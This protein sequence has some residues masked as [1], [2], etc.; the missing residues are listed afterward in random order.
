MIA[1]ALWLGRLSALRRT[2]N[3]SSSAV[4]LRNTKPIHHNAT[5]PTGL[6]QSM[7]VHQD[8]GCS[9]T[10]QPTMS[11]AMVSRIADRSIRQEKLPISWCAGSRGRPFTLYSQIISINTNP[12]T[13]HSIT[14]A[15]PIIQHLAHHTRLNRLRALHPL[16]QTLRKALT[17]RATNRDFAYTS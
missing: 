6:A 14:P 3:M 2:C 7:T 17:H 1:K 8:L 10:R 16:R 13:T 9:S 4:S 15:H 11:C 12:H 5:S